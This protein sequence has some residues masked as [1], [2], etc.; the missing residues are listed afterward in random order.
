MRIF[1]AT[2]GDFV[3][4]GQQVN[5]DHVVALRAQGHDARL[6]ILRR[7]GEPPGFAPSFPAGVA[8]PPWQATPEGLTADDVVVVG[9][10]FERG[11]AAL[12][13]S[14]ARKVVHNQNPYYMFQAFKDLDAMQRWG[15][16]HM[17]CASRF[18]ASYA[19]AA[20]WDGA[21]SVVRPSLDPIFF[22]GEAGPR[23]PSVAFMPRKRPLEARW[24]K[25]LLHSRRPDLKAVP[26]IEIKGMSR[27]QCAEA[28]KQ[29]GVFL[30]LGWAEGLGLP[31]LEAMAAG[32]LVVGFHGGGGRD[33]ATAENGDWF[34]DQDHLALI[35][36]LEARLDGLIAGADVSDRLAAGAATAAAFSRPRFEAELA[37]AWAAIL[38]G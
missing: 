37:G 8:P 7:A 38:G 3:A 19:S 10:M 29:A 5:L 14:R 23:A 33:Y 17:I 11:A 34:G 2:A 25:G 26:W 30:S 13:D 36:A 24:L 12:M 6:L 18:T 9:E 32:A 28:L 31:P 15:A 16:T 27:A 21:I 35:E 1:Y 4:G 20:G 22:G